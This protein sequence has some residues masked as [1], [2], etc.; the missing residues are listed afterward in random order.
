LFDLL[1]LERHA[2][3]SY[4]FSRVAPIAVMTAMGGR[5]NRSLMGARFYRFHSGLDRVNPHR[6]CAT[7]QLLRTEIDCLIHDG[8]L[9]ITG[10]GRQFTLLT[11]G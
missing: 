11:Q 6:G 5:F 8:E 2:I 7:A 1:D 10:T 4:R 3:Q 9:R